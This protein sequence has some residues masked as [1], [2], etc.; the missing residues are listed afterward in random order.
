MKLKQKIVKIILIKN[1]E[2]FTENIIFEINKNNSD[3]R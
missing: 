2:K 1:I 3:E